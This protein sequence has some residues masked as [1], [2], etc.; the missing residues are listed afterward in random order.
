MSDLWIHDYNLGP[1]RFSISIYFLFFYE[2]PESYSKNQIFDL[3]TF[4]AMWLC[5]SSAPGLSASDIGRMQNVFMEKIK[6]HIKTKTY[7]SI[8]L[9]S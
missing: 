4:L 5:V 7:I 1:G 8:Q 2:T 9:R 6:T 3:P